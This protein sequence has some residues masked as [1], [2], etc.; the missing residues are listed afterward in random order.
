MDGESHRRFYYIVSNAAF[1]PG[2]LFHCDTCPGDFFANCV[3][4]EH[5]GSS[6]TENT[7]SNKISSNV[8]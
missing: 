2:Q 6:S 7:N 5:V 1:G 8:C 3:Y 4:P